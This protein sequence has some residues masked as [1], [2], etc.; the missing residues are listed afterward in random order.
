VQKG[1]TS[2]FKCDALSQ[3]RPSSV[4]GLNVIRGRHRG[5]VRTYS[6]CGLTL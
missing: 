4:K 1:M 2:M 5:P 3:L 6:L